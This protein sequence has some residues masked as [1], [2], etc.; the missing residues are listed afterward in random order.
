MPGNRSGLKLKLL[1]CFKAGLRNSIHTPQLPFLKE[2]RAKWQTRSML[3]KKQLTEEYDK[4][5][6]DVQNDGDGDMR[7]VQTCDW[8]SRINTQLTHQP[9]NELRFNRQL[10]STAA[11][12]KTRTTATG[13]WRALT[14]QSTVT[15]SHRV[16]IP[17]AMIIGVN[18][19]WARGLEPPHFWGPMGSPI[20][21]PP[22]FRLVFLHSSLPRRQKNNKLSN[23]LVTKHS[24]REVSLAVW[25]LSF[26]LRIR[27]SDL[28]LYEWLWTALLTYK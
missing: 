10:I 8:L 9:E 12:N 18:S 25:K 26:C 7:C 1:Y 6:T 4:E 24:L 27:N 17:T 15:T 16:Y 21:K 20:V 3:I 14:V 2:C 23:R 22:T 19:Y 28:R 13:E 11:G 5:A